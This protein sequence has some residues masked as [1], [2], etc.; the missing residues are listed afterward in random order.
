ME[1]TPK[2]SVNIEAYVNQVQEKDKVDAASEQPEKQQVKAD[3]VELSDMGKRV[4]EAH[5]QL[6][7]I[8]DI[9]EDKV[10]EL[11]EQVENGTY[12]VD[13]EKVAD[14]MLKDALLN[15]LT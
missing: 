5:R 12:E 3:T 6:D 14:K 4:Q 9:R 10:A 11:K 13:A 1:I 8:P 2:D 15:D 7:S